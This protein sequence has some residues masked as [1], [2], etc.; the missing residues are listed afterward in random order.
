[1]QTPTYNALLTTPSAGRVN[2]RGNVFSN[3]P[4]ADTNESE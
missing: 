3:S 1:M 2:N 4:S